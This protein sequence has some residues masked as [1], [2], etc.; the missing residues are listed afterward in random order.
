MPGLNGRKRKPTALRLVD[1]NRG[2]RP[3]P[4]AEPKPKRGAPPIPPHVKSDPVAAEEWKRLAALTGAPS[5]G[6]L[7]VSDGPILEAT[8]LAYSTFRLASAALEKSLTYTCPTKNG[9]TMVRSRPEVFIAADAWRR[10]VV[11]LTH[12]GLSPATR[13]KV[14]ALPYD[15]QE[16]DPAAEFL[17]E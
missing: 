2:K 11:G 5:I 9:G 4:K 10:Y 6:V 14:S 13:S 8:V 12:F 17:G 3:L 7:T 1:G 15:G 16:K